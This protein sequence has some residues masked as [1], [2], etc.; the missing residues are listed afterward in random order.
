MPMGVTFYQYLG[1]IW[2]IL[3]IAAVALTLDEVATPFDDAKKIIVECVGPL[4][5]PDRKVVGG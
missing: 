4:V 2:F 1:P 3:I 5:Q